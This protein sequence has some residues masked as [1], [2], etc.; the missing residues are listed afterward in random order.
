MDSD[1]EDFVFFGTLIKCEEGSISRKNKTIA[2]SF[3]QLQTLPILL[4]SYKFIVRWFDIVFTRL[5]LRNHKK[6]MKR[7]YCFIL[8]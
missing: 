2:E 7:S 8:V 3:D 4:Y 1:K 6:K 5:L